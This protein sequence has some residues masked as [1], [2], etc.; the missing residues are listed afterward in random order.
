M[1][2][3]MSGGDRRKHIVS[4]IVEMLPTLSHRRTGQLLIGAGRP[5][6]LTGMTS[7]TGRGTGWGRLPLVKVQDPR[8]SVDDD[9]GIGIALFLLYGDVRSLSWVGNQTT[10]RSGYVRMRVFDTFSY[11]ANGFHV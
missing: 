9:I 10:I 8:V 2:E 11:G 1:F 6:S 3:S 5:E 4:C 7:G